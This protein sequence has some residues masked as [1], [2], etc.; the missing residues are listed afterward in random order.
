MKTDMPSWLPPMTPYAWTGA[1]VFFAISEFLILIAE[2]HGLLGTSLTRRLSLPVAVA[3]PLII[4][5]NFAR[6]FMR[7][8]ESLTS[9]AALDLASASTAIL[10]LATYALLAGTLAVLF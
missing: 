7:R 3:G 6:M 9:H 1:L 10:V 5:A 8:S 2:K 4:G